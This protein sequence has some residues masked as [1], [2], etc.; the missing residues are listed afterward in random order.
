[1]LRRWVVKRGPQFAESK[2]ACFVSAQR[3]NLHLEAVELDLERDPLRYSA[4]FGED[5][6]RVIQSRDYVDD[7]FVLT[8]YAVLY[9]DFVAE[10]KWIETHPLPEDHGDEAPPPN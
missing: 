7:G 9:D 5:S 4:A 2:D 10:I 1:V 8:V 3:L 6:R